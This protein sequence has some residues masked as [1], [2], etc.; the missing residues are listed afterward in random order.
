MGRL[1]VLN[2]HTAI[3]LSREG[4]FAFIPALAGQQRFVLVDLPAPKCERLCALINRA[5]L[6]AQPPPR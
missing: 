4:G 1:P 5:A 3:A 6:L 2:N